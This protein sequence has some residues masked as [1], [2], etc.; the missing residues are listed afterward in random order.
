MGS[1]LQPSVIH[2]TIDA[3]QIA[4]I[5]LKKGAA[6]GLDSMTEFRKFGIDIDANY[7]EGRTAA[8][9]AAN[10]NKAGYGSKGFDSAFDAA[11]TPTVTTPTVPGIVQMYQ[12][13][14]PGFVDIVKA[15]RK[16]DMIMPLQTAGSWEDEQI[17][18]GVMEHSGNAGIYSD[19]GN[20]LVMDWNLQFEARN[21]FRGE[22]G[23]QVGL[24]EQARAAKIRVSDGDEKR[25]AA[26]T[27][28]E[29]QRNNIAFSGVNDG[30]SLTYGMLNDPGLGAALTPVLDG[31]Q[32][33]WELISYLGIVNQI[34]GFFAQLQGQAGGVI[35]PQ[36]IATT[37]VIPYTIEQYL[38]KVDTNGQ[39]GWSV[40]SFMAATYPKCKIITCPQFVDA[41]GAGVNGLMLFADNV[42]GSGTDSG[43]TWVQTVPARLKALGVK[44][45]EK[46][47]VEDYSNATAGAWLL[48]PYAN[49]YYNGV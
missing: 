44:Q 26:L 33:K 3:K 38:N 12:Y 2:S 28:L 19:S 36:E 45:L 27:S 34:I 32:T 46:G 6:C 14:M 5:S 9:N 40:R 21:I 39:Q 18:Q 15:P 13:F 30:G 4:S 20:P 37:M 47:Y 8:Y 1:Q 16:A 41:G 17:V 35:D 25:K 43:R 24:L 48:R 23:M 49:V 31:G 42:E 7:L 22:A 10:K 29:I 11:I